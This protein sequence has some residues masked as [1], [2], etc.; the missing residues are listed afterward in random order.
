MFDHKAL[1]M[2]NITNT[3]NI[4]NKCFEF[5]FAQTYLHNEYKGLSC[6]EQSDHIFG[7]CQVYASFIALPMTSCLKFTRVR[8]L[9]Y[10][11]ETIISQ[12]FSVDFCSIIYFYGYL[13]TMELCVLTVFNMRISKY[14]Y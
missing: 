9:I 8:K 5:T 4:L 14:T 1:Q 2:G 11:I 10:V 6:T 3:K 12:N 7:K 13:L